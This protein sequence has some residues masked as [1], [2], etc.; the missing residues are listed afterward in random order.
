M[1]SVFGNASGTDQKDERLERLYEYTKFHIGIYLSAAA[2]VAT[3]LGSEHAGWFISQLVTEK[4]RH[5]LYVGLTLMIFAGMCG[6]VV[7]SSTIEHRRFEDFWNELQGP[8]SVPLLQ[9]HGRTWAMYEHLFFWCSVLTLAASI[10][11]GFNGASSASKGA[12]VSD[13]CCQS[14]SSASTG[15]AKKSDA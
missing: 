1:S 3:L 9:V 14:Q 15:C 12:A 13:G 5:F 4:N 11:F 6:G 8:Q 2:G 7:A 10:A